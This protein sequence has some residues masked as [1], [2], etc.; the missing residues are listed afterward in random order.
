MEQVSDGG[1]RL[2]CSRWLA[3]TSQTATIWTWG[4]P[5]K[6]CMSPVPWPPQ[7]IVAIT[8]RSLA[9]SLAPAPS[10]DDVMTHGTAI[11]DPAVWRNRRRLVCA[12]CI[13]RV[14]NDKLEEP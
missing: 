7:P 3:T 11:A 4:K 5:R 12:C 8:I 1:A 9:A 10:A 13:R 6:P 2:A 14:F